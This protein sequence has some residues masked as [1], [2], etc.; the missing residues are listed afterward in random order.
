H[1]NEPTR[2]SLANL[3]TPIVELAN[4]A[5]HLGVPK[6]LL[7]RDDC[8]G[9]ETSG[10][11]IRKREYVIADALKCGVDTLV[12]H[13][14]FQSNHCRATASIGARLGLKVRLLL[15]SGDPEPPRDVNLFLDELF[16]A[17]ITFHSPGEYNEQRQRLIDEAIE[18]ER[19]EGRMPY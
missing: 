12:T 3:P 19:S 9:F 18:A 14:G 1:A 15:R 10:N 4:L 13:G 8:T 16:G 11:K 6:I 17:K 2:L 7:K 5:K